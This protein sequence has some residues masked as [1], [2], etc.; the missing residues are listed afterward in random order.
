MKQKDEKLKKILIIDDDEDII[1]LIRIILENENYTVIG[2]LSGD[3]GIK[4]ALK[5]KPDLILLDI[6]MPGTDGWEVMKMLH[7]DEKTRKIP[8][9]MLTCKTDV[10]DKLTGLQEGAIDYITKPFS[11]EELITRVNKIFKIL[12]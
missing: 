3:E 8:V 2:A 12:T 1:S 6:M 9:A 4:Y 5:E 11:P 7:T 10:R